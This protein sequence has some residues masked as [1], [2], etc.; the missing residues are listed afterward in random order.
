MHC[1]ENIE[2]ALVSI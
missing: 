2:A 1:W